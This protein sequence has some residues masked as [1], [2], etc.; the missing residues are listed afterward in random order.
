MVFLNAAKAK[1]DEVV[2]FGIKGIT[3]PKLEKS[4]DKTHWLAWGDMKKAMMLLLMERTKKIVLL[5]K[6]NKEIVFKDT[7]NLDE[8][9]KSVLEKSR[10]KKDY[11][12]LNSVADALKKV[13]VEIIEPTAYLGGLIPSKG[14]ITQREPSDSEMADV[15]YGLKIARQLSDM[16]IGQSIAV[17]DKAVVAVEAAEGTDDM[18]LRAGRLVKDGFTVIKV[19]RPEQDMRFDIPLVG[20]DTLYSMEKAGASVLALEACRTFLMDKE[21]M[22]KFADSNDI[23]VVIV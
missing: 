16:D 7:A 22:I 6:I 8:E 3:D 14:I 18:I 17:K 23:S 1:G 5:G 4:A 13:G 12:I 2:V 15:K 9:A 20:P 21:E 11:A 10:D 19:A